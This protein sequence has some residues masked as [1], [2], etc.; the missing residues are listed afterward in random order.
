MKKKILLFCLCCFGIGV[1]IYFLPLLSFRQ[2]RPPVYIAVVGPMREANG[3]AMRQGVE[4]YREQIN[5]QGGIDGRKI[6]FLFRDDQ[7]D[8]EKAE[9][10]ARKLAEENK[11]YLV[12][13]HYYST[14]SLAAG[15]IYKRNGI[16]AITA[17]AG[18][19]SVISDNEWYFRTIPGESIEAKLVASYMY[20]FLAFYRDIPLAEIVKET[21]PASIIFS[22]DEYGRSLLKNF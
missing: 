14:A 19:E 15:K 11:I 18:V 3:K 2:E 10:I 17:S 12:L 8:A 22:S 5:K 16:P 4:L 21:I 20:D 6:K 13:G 9:G 7:N 1:G